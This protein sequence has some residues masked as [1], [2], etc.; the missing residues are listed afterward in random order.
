[1]RFTKLAIVGAYL[2]DLE[3]HLDERGFFGRTFCRSEFEN[4]GLSSTIAQCS[5]SFNTRRGTLRGLHYQSAPHE[6]AK[7]VRC[8]T[9]GIYDVIVDVRA[10]SPTFG[11]WYG[12]YL[13]AENRRMMYVPPG[14]AH[15]FQTTE[16]NTEVFYQI[17]TDHA[18]DAA[19]GIRWDDPHLAIAWPFREE[20][21]ISPRDAGFPGLSV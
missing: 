14:V 21:I 10:G 18:P 2:I 15:G 7:V 1:M 3:P 8:T 17:S 5:T 16:N 12:A 19:R 6:E 20:R 13:T 9:G 4:H 11:T